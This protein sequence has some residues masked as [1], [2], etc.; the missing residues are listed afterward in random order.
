[1]FGRSNSKQQRIVNYSF[2]KKCPKDVHATT[3]I[4]ETGVASAVLEFDNGTQG[5]RKI[6]EKCW[7]T[8][9]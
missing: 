6:Y 5:I 2:W 3:N 4:I 7:F 1:M 9:W 8:F